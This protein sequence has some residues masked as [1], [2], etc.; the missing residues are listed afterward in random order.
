MSQVRYLVLSMLAIA[1]MMLGTG[2][3]AAQSHSPQNYGGPGGGMIRGYVLG[4]DMYDQLQPV[5]W[6]TIYARNGQQVLPP[7]YSDGG[8]YY[9]M[10][11]PAGTYNVTV[12]ETGF[13]PY[14]STVAVTNGSTSSI[15]F[16]LEESHVP[17]PEFPAGM[18][19]LITIATLSAALLA[20]RRAKRKR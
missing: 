14:S 6:A 3:V 4:F 13:K 16:Y 20:M 19:T 18:A 1:L 15:N 7:A 5:A 9:E 10:Y 8:G 2:F 12:V 11:V 17:V